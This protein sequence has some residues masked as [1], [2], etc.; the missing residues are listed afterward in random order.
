MAAC[1]GVDFPHLNNMT[2]RHVKKHNL[3]NFLLDCSYKSV[4]IEKITITVQSGLFRK[5][6]DFINTPKYVE[7]HYICRGVGKL[8]QIRLDG[9]NDMVVRNFFTL[10]HL[11]KKEMC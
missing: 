6:G 1:N 10:S 8:Y 4:A 2:H 3:H 5:L 7:Q 9:V 11:S